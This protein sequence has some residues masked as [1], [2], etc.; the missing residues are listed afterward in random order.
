MLGQFKSSRRPC[1]EARAYQFEDLF[2][3][4]QI[5]RGNARLLTSGEGA[6]IGIGN[7]ARQAQLERVTIKCSGLQ[8]Q[9]GT[10]TSSR[11]L[12]PE[13]QL[14]TGRQCGVEV[15]VGPFTARSIL[16]AV[17]LASQQALLIA[18]AL[19]SRLG[20]RGPPAMRSSAR[21]CLTLAMA[22]RR[23]WLPRRACSISWLS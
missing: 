8:A 17:A 15:A 19:A 4:F 9:T 7:A 18:S 11:I 5:E 6:Q 13:V 23:S 21:A 12:A 2:G 20:S 10:V 3:V 14:V 16:F 1:L 22:A